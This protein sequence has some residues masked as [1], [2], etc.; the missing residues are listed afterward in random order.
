[1]YVLGGI[2]SSRC[3][4]GS[5]LLC[6]LHHSS[7]S[8]KPGTLVLRGVVPLQVDSQATVVPTRLRHN[9]G[10]I[11]NLW[12]VTPESPGP[13]LAKLK[14]GVQ[15]GRRVWGLAQPDSWRYR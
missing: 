14:E 4:S 3:R 6:D 12:L 5:E 13:P 11:S 2:D 15:S 1:M 7:S 9:R 10:F 8:I